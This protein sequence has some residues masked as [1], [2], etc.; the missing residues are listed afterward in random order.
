MPANGKVVRNDD[1]S[2]FRSWL[3]RNKLPRSSN[4][5]TLA[6][7]SDTGRGLLATNDVGPGSAVVE[8]PWSILLTKAHIAQYFLDVN[9][10]YQS[11]TEI[12]ILSMFIYLLYDGANP[13]LPAAVMDF[14]QPYLNV[15]PKKFETVGGMIPPEIVEKFP[16]FV[17]GL[18]DSPWPCFFLTF[19]LH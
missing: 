19:E 6:E 10:L 7:F 8:I 12:Q 15:L 2:A 3:R 13:L 11:L 1:W 14:W 4:K 5:L 17:Q 9:L 16:V 18:L